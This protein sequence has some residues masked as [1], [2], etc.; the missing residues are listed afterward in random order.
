V[1]MG[2]IIGVIPNPLEGKLRSSAADEDRLVL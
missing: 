2:H 1:Q